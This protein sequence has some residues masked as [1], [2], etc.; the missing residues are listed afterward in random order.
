MELVL[1]LETHIHSVVCT[2]H[3]EVF[4]INMKS[5]ERLITRKNQ[6]TLTLLRDHVE[7][8]MRA[9]AHS[10]LGS[11]I[12]LYSRILDHLEFTRPKRFRSATSDDKVLQAVT[13]EEKSRQKT[14]KQL[15]KL[16][17]KDRSPLIDPFVP[18]AVYYKTKAVEK[19]GKAVDKLETMVPEVGVANVRLERARKAAHRQPRSR[20]ELERLTVAQDPE[21]ITKLQDRNHAV[22][23]FLQRQPSGSVQPRPKSAVVTSN[24]DAI[25]KLTEPQVPDDGEEVDL[26]DLSE[27]EVKAAVLSVGRS[28]DE[29][30]AT[31]SRVICSMMERNAFQNAQSKYKHLMRP[32]SAPPEQLLAEDESD[33]AQRDVFDSDT[34]DATLAQLET[35][36]REFHELHAD[37]THQTRRTAPQVQR[38]RRFNISVSHFRSFHL[39]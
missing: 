10:Q 12:L 33:A 38:L 5:I 31:R 28:S 9:R 21:E 17:L 13:L 36:I 32:L 24:N 2:A 25:H 26:T 4:H 30:N 39:P 7:Q 18:G 16:Y 27:S 37:G 19:E 35:K 3:T 14:L 8:R 6:T 23:R 22:N 20:R 15:V 29:T 11:D 34:S 1:N